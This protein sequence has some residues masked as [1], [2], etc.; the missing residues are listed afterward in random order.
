MSRCFGEGDPVYAAYHDD[1]WGRPV[2][3]E[4]ALFE[5]LCL[6]SFQSGLSW[7]LVLGRRDALRAAFAGF[8]PDVLAAFG[9]GDVERILA[10]PGVIRHRGKVE[11]V[12]ANARATVSLRRSAGLPALVWS[13]HRTEETRPAPQHW[14]DVPATAPEAAAL[15]AAL[16]RNGFRFVGPT[17]AYAFMQAVGVVND[18]LA[19]CPVRAEVERER[20][21]MRTRP[22]DR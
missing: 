2:T 18:H 15:A 19:G 13:F 3:D 10:L 6:E 17:T 20:A 4:R 22:V 14:N 9:E 12:I 1:E 8:G 21:G 16:R 7:R 11:A 5:L